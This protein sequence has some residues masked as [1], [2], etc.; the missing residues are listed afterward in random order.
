MWRASISTGPIFVRPAFCQAAWHA[1]DEL[2]QQKESVG[3][4]AGTAYEFRSCATRCLYCAAVTC[5][6]T[7]RSSIS[8]MLKSRRRR[9]D[10]VLMGFKSPL[11]G[12]N[13]TDCKPCLRYTA[14][15]IRKLS[16]SCHIFEDA[17]GVCIPA[18]RKAGAYLA[19]STFFIL[20]V[21]TSAV[22]QEQ[23]FQTNLSVTSILG[24]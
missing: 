7:R 14:G 11:H 17:P 4:G 21:G 23:C 18:R 3:P 15:L 2:L 10:T 9:A 20:G 12:G 22:L 8:R 16:L 19:H 1:L 13:R 6:P 5:L 24:S